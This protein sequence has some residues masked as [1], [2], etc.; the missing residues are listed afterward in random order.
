MNSEENKEKLNKWLE[1]PDINFSFENGSIFLADTNPFFINKDGIKSVLSRIL[2][3]RNSKVL[4]FFIEML[5]PYSQHSIVKLNSLDYQFKIVVFYLKK[6]SNE[7]V[8]TKFE[9]SSIV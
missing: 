7:E 1:K 5:I 2:N 4:D 8:K 3:E 6:L 9:N